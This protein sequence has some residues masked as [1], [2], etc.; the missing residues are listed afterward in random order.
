MSDRDPAPDRAEVIA[1]IGAAVFVIVAGIA[2]Y[3]AARQ[4][5]AMRRADVVAAPAGPV[6]P[7]P[8]PTPPA[9][10]GPGTP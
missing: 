3:V 7:I 6:P 10:I 8:V 4:L 1:L 5:A 2:L 9:P